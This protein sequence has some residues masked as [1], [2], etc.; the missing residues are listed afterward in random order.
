MVI[1]A[2]VQGWVA[3]CIAPACKASIP[4]KGSGRPRPGKLGRV[5]VWRLRCPRKRRTRCCS[6]GAPILIAL[7]RVHCADTVCTAHACVTAAPV[8]CRSAIGS[9]DRSMNDFSEFHRCPIWNAYLAAQRVSLGLAL[10]SPAALES[11][12][13]RPRVS[14]ISRV[15]ARPSPLARAVAMVSRNYVYSL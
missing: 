6:P 11:L 15:S 14:A 4:C 8:R 3:V 10:G 12:R 9:F 5:C 7:G 2:W 13:P 1:H